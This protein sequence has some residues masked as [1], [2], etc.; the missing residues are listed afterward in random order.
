MSVC[1]AAEDN[2]SLAPGLRAA[3]RTLKKAASRVRLEPLSE[4]MEGVLVDSGWLCRLEDE[5]AEG[6]ARAANVYKACRLAR[7]I[8]RRKGSGPAQTAVELRAHIEIA[9][10]APGSLSSKAEICFSYRAKSCASS[11]QRAK[12][13]GAASKRTK[14]TDGA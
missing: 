3:V 8:E 4:V 14:N 11:T 1:A 7:D 6:L 2:A 5:G 9:K 13:Q 12:C 10:E